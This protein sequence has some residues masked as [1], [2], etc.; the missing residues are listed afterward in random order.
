M[1]RSK[2][3]MQLGVGEGNRTRPI[4]RRNTMEGSGAARQYGAAHIPPL[5]RRQQEVGLDKY[6]TMVL[7]K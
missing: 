4:L 6:E 3:H 7:R 5:Q 2:A 1:R